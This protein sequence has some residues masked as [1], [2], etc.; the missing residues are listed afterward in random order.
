MINKETQL[1]ISAAKSPGNFGAIIYNKLFKI[2]NI[3]AIYLPRKITDEINLIE[4]I[5]VLDIRGCSVT[6]PFKS[7]VIEYMDV[8]DEIALKTNSVNTIVNKDSKL[9]GYNADYYGAFDILSKLNLRSVLIYGSG[10]VTNSII[11]ALKNSFCNDITIIAR[12]VNKAKE[13]SEKYNLKCSLEYNKIYDILINTTPAS[14]EKEHE[15]YSFLPCVSVVFDLVVSPKQ[16][17]LILRSRKY[18]I[19]VIDGV[20]MSKFQIKKQFEIYTGIVCDISLINKIVNKYYKMKE[21]NVYTGK[22]Y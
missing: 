20:E 21:I 8:L 14:I 17:E 13:I 6:M 5:K 1:F 19:S 4:T 12:D 9:Y 3:N 15:M 7:K 10:S 22:T 2:Y 18:G 11:L 16:T